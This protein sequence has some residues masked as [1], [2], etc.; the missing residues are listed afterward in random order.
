MALDM[1]SVRGVL[2]LTKRERDSPSLWP[3]EACCR[4]IIND[5]SY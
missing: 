1:P 5:I 4:L 2:V 3:N